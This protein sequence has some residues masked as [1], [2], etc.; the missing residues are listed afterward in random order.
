MTIT[1]NGKLILK[2]PTVANI[3]SAIRQVYVM[4]WPCR[5]PRVVKMDVEEQAKKDDDKLWRAK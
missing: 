1:S 3:H 5:K 4:T 2:A